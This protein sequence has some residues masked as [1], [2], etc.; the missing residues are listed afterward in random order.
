MELCHS[1]SIL[2]FVIALPYTVYLVERYLERRREHPDE[3]TAE[4]LT[5][6]ARSIWMPCVFSALTTMAG[7]AAFTTS[8]AAESTNEESTLSSGQIAPRRWG[9]GAQTASIRPAGPLVRPPP[10]A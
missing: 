2:L 1:S 4:A 9:G 8:G 5:G 6:A 3:D 7:F 10:V